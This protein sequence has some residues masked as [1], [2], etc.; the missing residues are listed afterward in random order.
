MKSF[1][2][3]LCI[4]LSICTFLMVGVCTY[5]SASVPNWVYTTAF[6]VAQ[7][8]YNTIA[9]NYNLKTPTIKKGEDGHSWIASLGSVKFNNRTEDTGS[10]AG[11]KVPIKGTW[12][13]TRLDQWI[14]LYGYKRSFGSGSNY[15]A[16]ATITPSGT[17]VDLGRV[18]LSEKKDYQIRSNSS[19]AGEYDF[20]FIYTDSETWDLNVSFYDKRWPDVDSGVLGDKSYITNG[21]SVK[22]NSKDKMYEII[23]DN[24]YLLDGRVLRMAQKADNK[25]D[26]TIW[27]MRKLKESKFDSTVGEEV[28]QIFGR[29]VGEKIFFTD[30]ISDIVYNEERNVSYFVFNSSSGDDYGLQFAGDMREKFCVGEEITLQFSVVKIG[31]IENYSFES[32]DY[33]EDSAFE[34]DSA[35]SIFDYLIS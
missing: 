23:G 9:N 13:Q 18:Y 2:N 27:D 5:A 28:D 32:I 4:L 25:Q 8:G 21:K 34:Q 17:Y 3:K 7:Y 15:L 29:N 24:E 26:D 22:T 16:L 6:K 35:P 10:S 1:K 31:E 12:K 14:G 11:Y 30:K 20:R 19:N 33:L